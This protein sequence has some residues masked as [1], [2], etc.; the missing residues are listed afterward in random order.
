MCADNCECEN[1]PPAFSKFGRNRFSMSSFTE[2]AQ[3]VIAIITLLS[4]WCIFLLERRPGAVIHGNRSDEERMGRFL[5]FFERRSGGQMLT[6]TPK[7]TG[8]QAAHRTHLSI[9]K[10]CTDP[11]FRCHQLS[12]CLS[13]LVGMSTKAASKEDAAGWSNSQRYLGRLMSASTSIGAG[14][15]QERGLLTHN[16]KGRCPVEKHRAQQTVSQMLR[17]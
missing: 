10:Q 16:G 9:C 2:M 17:S 5:H 15:L 4:M 1:S 14:R 13:V 6:D 11:V 12:L 8:A 3:A 7:R